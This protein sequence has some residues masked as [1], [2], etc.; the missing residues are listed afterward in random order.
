M[1]KKSAELSRA[2]RARAE[3]E[4]QQAADR[5]RNWIVGGIVALLVVV[6]VVVGFVLTSSKDETG[7]VATDV[8]TGVTG[9][10]GVLVGDDGAP[11]AVT[12]YEDPQCP[13]CAQFESMSRDQVQ[14]AID[15]GR[16]QVEY[17][18]V[19]FL[20]PHSTN[21]YS[22]RAAN[23]LMVVNETSGAEVFKAY[24]D[25]LFE[26]QPAENTAGPSNST[27]IDWAVE[28]GAKRA[29]VT[30]GIEDDI[31]HQWVINTADEMSKAGVTGTPTVFIDGKVVGEGNP[32]EALQTLLDKLKEGQ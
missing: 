24:H 4:R 12:I 10:G 9:D 18:V 7:G 29:D 21:K 26:R 32:Q 20:D 17:R 31:Y 19:S 14:K 3:I 16:A 2:E 27:L 30:P 6:V 15:D 13:I 11:V 22:S 5:R 28:A 1:S 25:L 23:A 8:P